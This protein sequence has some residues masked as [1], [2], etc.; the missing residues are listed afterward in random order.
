MSKRSWNVQRDRKLRFV[1]EVERRGSASEP[2][3]D[4]RGGLALAEDESRNEEPGASE[5]I[6][7]ERTLTRR[8]GTGDRVGSRMRREPVILLVEETVSRAATVMR[9]RN[10]D[11]VVVVNE[12]NDLCGIL[13]DRD[14]MIHSL[15]Y[16]RNPNKVR[17]GELCTDVTIAVR[18]WTPL[19]EAVTLMRRHAVGRLPVLAGTRLVGVI[20]IKDAVDEI[21]LHAMLANTRE[22][23]TW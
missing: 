22:E 9:E 17:L 4:Q 6:L 20:S 11:E 21:E 13:T 12:D 15:G 5:R 3:T 7:S 19:D 18:P 2:I 23:A 14:L 10:V 8:H 1:R 16:G